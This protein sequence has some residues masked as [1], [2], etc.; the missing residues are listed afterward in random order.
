GA[1]Q[2]AFVGIV[3]SGRGIVKGA[4]I[5][6]FWSQASDSVAVLQRNLSQEVAS[7]RDLEARF[8]RWHD[9]TVDLPGTY[10][11]QVVHWIFREN[12]IANGTFVALGH[13]VRLGD[14]KIPVFLLAGGDDEIVPAG[15]A[16]AT[17]SS[18]GTPASLIERASVPSGH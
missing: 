6:R 15:Q 9:E 1:P 5:L 16:M 13:T 4:H 8:V 11:L 7:D 10:Y 12:R 2:A 18:L 17:P 3:E 14:V